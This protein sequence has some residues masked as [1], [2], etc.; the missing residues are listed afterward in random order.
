MC[1]L[2]GLKYI[3]IKQYFYFMKNH[4]QPYTEIIEQS[5]TT[6]IS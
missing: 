2:S 5:Y 6:S 3:A 1:V 4:K